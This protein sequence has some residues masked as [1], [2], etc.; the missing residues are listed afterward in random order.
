[1]I[2]AKLNYTAT[3]L[4]LFLLKNHIERV[5]IILFAL[6]VISAYTGARKMH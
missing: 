2:I 3:Y 5:I 6:I 1:M 4:K